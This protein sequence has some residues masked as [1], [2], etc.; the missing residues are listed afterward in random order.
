MWM[1]AASCL[2][3]FPFQLPHCSVSKKP[4]GS[5]LVNASL[6][7]CWGLDQWSCAS[8]G[9][10]HPEFKALSTLNSL[11]RDSSTIKSQSLGSI[12]WELTLVSHLSSLVS[13]PSSLVPRLFLVSSS[14]L[15][16]SLSLASLSLS[17]SRVSLSPLSLSLSRISLLKVGS[18]CFLFILVSCDFL[19]PG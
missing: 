13:R 4:A 12:S 16:L 14:S 7:R 6:W 10:L 19:S 3:M 5:C 18:S 17:L 8:S 2:V 1:D 11:A 15:P 9:F